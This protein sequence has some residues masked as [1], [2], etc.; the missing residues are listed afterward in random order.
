[1]E[2][3]VLAGGDYQQYE[4]LLF[5]RDQLDKEA[6]LYEMAYRREFGELELKGYE[7]RVDCIGLKKS[8]A[9]CQ[10]MLNR[11]ETIDED[12]MKASVEWQMKAYRQQI[13]EMIRAN[14]ESE[15]KGKVSAYQAREIKK[16]Y[17]RIAKLIHPDINPLTKDDADLRD[18]FQRA[19]TAYRCNSLKELRETEVLINRYLK[20]QGFERIETSIPNIEEKIREL[21]EEIAGILSTEPYTYKDLLDDEEQVEAI[22]KR[23][24]AEVAEYEDYKQRLSKALETMLEGGKVDWQ[25]IMK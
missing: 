25:S 4:D 9:Y 22:K 23:L 2:L 24:R 8:I 6:G 19:I 7:L 21:E 17:R 16:I 1:M 5:Q 15:S 11:G 13:A 20:E 12:K 18:L 14:K 3:I 10:K